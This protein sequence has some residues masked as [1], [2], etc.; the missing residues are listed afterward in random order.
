MELVDPD[1]I[2]VKPNHLMPGPSEVWVTT[3]S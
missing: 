1:N 3:P 2:P